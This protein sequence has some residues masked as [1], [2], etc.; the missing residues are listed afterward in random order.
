M[1][2]VFGVLVVC[3]LASC[4]KVC[5]GGSISLSL[6]ISLSV[7]VCCCLCRLLSLSAAVC[8]D[9]A[10]LNMRQCGTRTCIHIG[11]CECMRGV[12]VECM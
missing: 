8:S 10:C 11:V 7:S 3:W 1:C 6:S 9:C 2:G 5:C 12:D 4:F